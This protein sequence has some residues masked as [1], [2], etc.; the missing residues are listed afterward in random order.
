MGNSVICH[1][2]YYFDFMIWHRIT[3]NKK[4]K[5]EIWRGNLFF[6]SNVISMNSRSEVLLTPSVISLSVCLFIR[7]F[8]LQPLIE[9]FLIF[10][11]NLGLSSSL[12][13][14]IDTDLFWNSKWVQNKVFQVV[15]KVDTRNFS[16]FSHE[17]TT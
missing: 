3:A 16:Y 4:I 15:W 6:L 2:K 12:K 14:V 10:C 13:K 1:G 17:V 9:L 5:K 7:S 11:I 8:H